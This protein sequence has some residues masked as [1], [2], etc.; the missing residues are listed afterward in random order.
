MSKLTAEYVLGTKK[1]TH[2]T[3][4]TQLTAIVWEMQTHIID[5]YK[6][7]TVNMVETNHLRIVTVFIC[8]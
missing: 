8:P 5:K 6:H 3:H 2:I 1:T 7:M 4:V